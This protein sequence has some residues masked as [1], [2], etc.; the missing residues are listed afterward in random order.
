M[1]QTIGVPLD[2]KKEL[3]CVLF[4]FYFYIFMTYTLQSLDLQSLNALKLTYQAETTEIKQKIKNA[5]NNIENKKL[6]NSKISK[7]L[8][9]FL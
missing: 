4:C 3:V 1:Q 2:M 8:A 6:K 5:A 7:Y 9:I